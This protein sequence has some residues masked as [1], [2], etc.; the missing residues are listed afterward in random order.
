MKKFILILISAIFSA[1]AG[2]KLNVITTIFPQ[3]DFVR[4]IAGD[5]VNLTMLLTPGAESHSFEPSPRELIAIQ[6]SDLFIHI[7]GEPWVERAL[8]SINTKNTNIFAMKDKVVLLKVELVEGMEDLGIFEQPRRGIFARLFPFLSQQE[9]EPPCII[10][11]DKHI[12]LSP[13]NAALIVQ[14]ITDTLSRLDPKNAYF[15]RKNAAAYIAQLE[16][17]DARFREIT[18]GAKRNTIIFSD[19]FPF[20]YLTRRYGLNHFAAF[21]ICGTQGDPSAAT[22]AFLINKIRAEQIPVIFH[23]ELSNERI[24]DTISRETGARKLLLHSLH[25]L[26]RQDFESG[27]GYLDFMHRNAE[28]LR[29]A[30]W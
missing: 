12:W 9:T 21:P 25:N 4:N 30:L 23:I 20:V 15:F 26:S 14:A 29:E 17:L 27:L 16:E 1:F 6:N 10:I 22:I 18:V 5:R 11:H 2:E 24:A 7:G 3:F 13:E 19:R 28:N 8:N